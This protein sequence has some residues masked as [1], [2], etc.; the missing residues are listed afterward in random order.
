MIRWLAEWPKAFKD[1]S[2]WIQEVCTLSKPKGYFDQN[3]VARV[4]AN[5]DNGHIMCY[6]S[7]LTCA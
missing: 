5:I 6:C 7:T 4:S 2:Q 1:I 3:L